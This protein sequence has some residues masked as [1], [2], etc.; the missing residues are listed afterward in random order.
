MLVVMYALTRRLFQVPFEWARLVQVVVV[1]AV[2]V[3]GRAA[4]AD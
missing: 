1:T 4:A 2:A 3:A